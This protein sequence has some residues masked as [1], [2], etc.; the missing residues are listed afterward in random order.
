V[1]GKSE[2]SLSLAGKICKILGIM[3]DAMLTC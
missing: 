2:P 3:P 1:K